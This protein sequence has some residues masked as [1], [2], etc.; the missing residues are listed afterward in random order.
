MVSLPQ[1]SVKVK[2]MFLKS[3]IEKILADKDT[4]K[5]QNAQ[6][7]KACESALGTGLVFVIWYFIVID[8]ILI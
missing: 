7:K 2:E 1:D 8:L 6:L 5:S 4:K 3:A